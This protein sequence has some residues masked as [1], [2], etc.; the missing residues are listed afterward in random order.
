MTFGRGLLPLWKLHPDAT[1][2]NHG[3][4]GATPREV[5]QAQQDFRDQMEAQPVDFFIRRLPGLIREAADQLAVFVGAD[6]VLL[7]DNA[8][9]GVNAVVRSLPLA[10]GDRIVALSHVYP[11]VQN[12]LHYACERSGAVLRLVP[13]GLP[14]DADRLLEQLDAALPARLAV[15]DHI[16][17]ASGLVLPIER[18][19]ALC[20]ERNTPVLVDGAHA[21]GM[22]PLDLGRQGATWYTGNC[23]KWLCAPKGSA[24]LWA[25]EEGREQLHPVVISHGY[26]NLRDEFEFLGTRDYTPWLS[27]P[28]ALAFRHKLGD[29]A[30]RRHNHRLALQARA[31]LLEHLDTEATGPESMVGSMA[32]V[33][34]PERFGE[35]VLSQAIAL[36]ERLWAE[37][38]VELPF[39]AFDGALWLRISAQV[40]NEPDDYRRLV[41]LL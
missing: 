18:M 38:R 5:L 15:L 33:R 14:A 20:R 2:L 34:L 3:S 1:Y 27:L 26:G 12:V 39:L 31:L 22:I 21:P 11:A 8:T 40:Y 10:R 30:I 25:S 7:V 23:H 9:T 4:F 16:T 28:A 17:S 13:I 32:C 6:E 24:F 29:E 41:G 19:V 36:N 37:H 35:P